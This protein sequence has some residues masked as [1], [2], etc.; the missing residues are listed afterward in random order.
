M[1]R[2]IDFSKCEINNRMYGGA[3]GRKLGIVY[4]NENYLLKFP[5]DLKDM[6]TAKMDFSVSPITEYIGSKVYESIGL[7]VHEVKL[8]IY[9]GIQVAACKDFLDDY[10]KLIEF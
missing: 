2:M 6:A 9:N 3:A 5:E 1:T 4:E 10:E 7:P 8:G